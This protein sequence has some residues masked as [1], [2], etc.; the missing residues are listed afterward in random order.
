MIYVD[1]VVVEVTHSL[2][3]VVVE[4][5]EDA[6][7]L[8]LSWCA[9]HHLRISWVG[10][11]VLILVQLLLDIFIQNWLLLL[12]C[13]CSSCSIELP[14]LDQWLF[15]WDQ[16]FCHLLVV[17]E[18]SHTLINPLVGRTFVKSGYLDIHLID[19]ID[20]DLLNFILLLRFF[21]HGL[22]L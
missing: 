5:I 3:Y 15:I 10:R 9:V 16:F 8:S 2:V 19:S 7:G 20:V 1:A 11:T 17:L 18:K 22:L 6:L 21:Y 12:S 14:Y 4:R 13:T